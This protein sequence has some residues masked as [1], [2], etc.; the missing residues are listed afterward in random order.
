VDKEPEIS[1]WRPDGTLM[2]DADWKNG[3]A[4]SLTV[5]LPGDRI[6]ETDD[7][8]EPI[9]DDSFLLLINAH[10]DAVPFALPA[11]ATGST[12][13]VEVTTDTLDGSAASSDPVGVEVLM[14]ARSVL[15]LRE[16]G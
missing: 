6:T 11:P 14:Q 16:T 4:R 5:A 15:L 3:F 7:R 10:H 1:W 8:G 12:W 2:A 13:V 9:V